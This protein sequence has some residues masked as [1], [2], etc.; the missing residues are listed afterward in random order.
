HFN[1][2]DRKGLM[3]YGQ[4]TAG[5]WIYIGSQGIVQG[6]YET[7]AELGRRHYGGDLAGRWF[8]TAGLGGLGGAQPLAATIAGASVLASERQPPRIE[9]RLKPRS[10]DI[11][12]QTL[13]EA[14]TI[15]ERACRAR[16]P[17]SVGL[18]GNA[19][20]LLPAL[21]RRGV[22]PDA[23]TDQ[24]SAHDPIN[25]YLPAGWS[26]GQWEER[27]ASDPKGVERAAKD[28]MAVHVRAMLAFWRRG[29]PTFDY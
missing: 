24:T 20:E 27:R 29:V 5:S 11:Q 18:L 12:A 26:L 4:M 3:M 15:I 8:L 1:E 14:M 2:L 16:A 9:M 25:G 21:V 13:D 23:V 28:S 17:V 19:A 7:F 6:T 22:K 10:L